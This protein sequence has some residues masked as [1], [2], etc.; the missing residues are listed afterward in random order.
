MLQRIFHHGL[1][2][3]LSEDDDPLDRTTVVT[4]SVEHILQKK[5]DTFILSLTVNATIKTIQVTVYITLHW[6]SK[7]K[8]IHFGKVVFDTKPDIVWLGPIIVR[9][10]VWYNNLKLSFRHDTNKLANYKIE[11]ANSIT[12][13]VQLLTWLETDT[14][15]KVFFFM[16]LY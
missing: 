7:P 11:K 3:I 15:C 9:Q 13:S 8:H 2:T 16:F 14:F 1:N 10:T 12:P 6:L 4:D 5:T